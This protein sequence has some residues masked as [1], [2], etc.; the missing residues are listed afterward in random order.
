MTIRL[1]DTVLTTNG[2]GIVLGIVKHQGETDL[3]VSHDPGRLA[4]GRPEQNPEFELAYPIEAVDE[5]PL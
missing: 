1:F 3:I 2:P 5:L 4:E